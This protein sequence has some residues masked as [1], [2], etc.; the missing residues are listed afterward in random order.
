[1]IKNALNLTNLQAWTVL[2][3]AGL[4]EIVWALGLRYTQG[5]TRLGPSIYTLLTMAVSVF[6]LSWAVRFLPVGTAYA[7]WTGIGAIGTAVGGVLLFEESADLWRVF[8]ILLI[9]AGI[10]GL[11]LVS[12]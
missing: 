5:F 6:L 12:R 11:K 1:M 8:S 2:F 10:I 3:F 9:V 7:V 4:F